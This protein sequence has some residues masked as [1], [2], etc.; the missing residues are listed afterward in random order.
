M[1]GFD[2]I[3]SKTDYHDVRFKERQLTPLAPGQVRLTIDRIALTA[4]N[5]SYA[6]FADFAGYW[7]FFPS[8]EDGFGRVPF[9]GFADV[10][11]SLNDSIPAGTRV[12][13]YLPASS[14]LIVEPAAL[15]PFGFTDASSHRDGL[16]AFYN[17]YHLTSSD[18][19]YIESFEDMQMLVRP[20]Y[21]TGW[22]LDDMLM[23]RE[24]PPSQ[25]IV[26]SAS[27]KTAMAYGLKAKERTGLHLTGLTSQRNADFV[28]GTGIY[29]TVVTYDA[30]SN[31]PRKAPTILCDFYGDAELRNRV[32]TELGDVIIANVAIGGTNWN[33]PRGDTETLGPQAEFFFAPSHADLCAKR[34]GGEAFVK[35]LNGDMVAVYPVMEQYVSPERREGQTSV[36][37]SW[38]QTL[39][40]EISPQTGLILS[41]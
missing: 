11:E 9:W 24:T 28:K 27:S 41:L 34:M 14:D 18:I 33:A 17:R 2:L 6:V 16:P 3:V 32:N 40:G 29:D 26:T 25:V 30:L 31:L 10:T 15:G 39:N 23:S 37:A 8:D 19:A 35:A 4:N 21:A 22:L 38:E 5:V 1:S 7:N 36:L 20:L 12:Y 13:G